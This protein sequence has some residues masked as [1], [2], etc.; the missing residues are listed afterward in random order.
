MKLNLRLLNEARQARIPL[1]L[2]I[3]LGLFGGILS[4]LQ[5]R[6]ISQV[7]NRVFLEGNNLESVSILLLSLLLIILVSG[8]LFMGW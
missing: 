8:R 4:I 7:I 1:V 3:C 6:E 5:A 2:S